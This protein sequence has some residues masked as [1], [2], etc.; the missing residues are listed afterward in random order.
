MKKQKENKVIGFMVNAEITQNGEPLEFH[1]SFMNSYSVNPE[2]QGVLINLNLHGIDEDKQPNILI[3]RANT[4]QLREYNRSTK[5][6]AKA[7]FQIQ[8]ND[9]PA[10][11][12]FQFEDGSYKCDN[13]FDLMITAV[14]NARQAEGMTRAMIDRTQRYG[15]DVKR[16]LTAYKN[17]FG[18]LSEDQKQWMKEN[19]L[20]Y[21]E[22]LAAHK[23]M[24]KTRNGG[25]D[26]DN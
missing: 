19:T 22:E 2:G 17:F 10:Y 13:L 15:H 20:S 7:G 26:N 11:G 4:Q 16:H 6:N 9:V 3:T 18:D 21:E 25:Q 24:L 1:K 12:I 8:L 14:G 5:Q 23:Q